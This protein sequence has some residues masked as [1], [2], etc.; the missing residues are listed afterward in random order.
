MNNSGVRFYIL[1]AS[2]L[3]SQWRFACRLAAR[4]WQQRRACHIQ[5]AEASQLKPFGELLWSF[6]EDSFLPHVVAAESVSPEPVVLGCTADHLVDHSR[7]LINLADGVP[8]AAR[9]FSA[10]AEIVVQDPVLL[11]SSRSRL[12]QYRELGLAVS[13]IKVPPPQG[14]RPAAAMARAEA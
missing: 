6:R 12:V 3:A 7:V 14:A 8:E 11:H 1:P 5:L 4:C 2:D 13:W 9:L 10:V